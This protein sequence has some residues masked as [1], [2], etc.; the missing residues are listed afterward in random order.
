MGEKM[1]GYSVKYIVKRLLG[2]AL[3]LYIA[4]TINF[5]LPRM[6][7]G[8]PAQYIA[9]QTAMNSP[10]YVELLRREFGLDKG[11]L[12]QYGAYFVQLLHLNFGISYSNFP[13]EVKT[14]ILRAMPWTLFIVLTSTLISFAIAWITGTICAMKKGSIYDRV[15]V[16]VSFY[17]QALPYYFVAMM[18]L[19]LFAFKL[20]WFPLSHALS[21]RARYT[22]W[23][24][25]LGDILYHGFLPIVSLILVNLAGRMI[26]MRSNVLQIFSEDYIVLA[27]A[28]GLKKSTILSKYALRNAMLPS[29]TGLMTSL[30]QAVAGAMVTEL[31]FSY[32][33]IGLTIYNAIMNRD[34]PVIQG[35]FAII[36]FCTVIMNLVAD[37]IY[38]LIDPRVSLS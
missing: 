30:G 13:T 14:I 8:D 36:A 6:M 33:G 4:L 16:G 23:V 25:K 31:I 32:P 10:E 11:Y 15:H 5:I 3:T 35:C 7:G 1:R 12:A 28:K 37:L 34:Y 21:T 9:S 24:G 29:F 38:P 22:T 18:L 19:M 20:K 17:I 26:M 27:Q 2:A